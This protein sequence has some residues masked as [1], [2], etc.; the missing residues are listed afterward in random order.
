MEKYNLK[1]KS[2]VNNN[3]EGRIMT[4][5]QDVAESYHAR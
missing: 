1:N 5:S 2:A 3:K 4:H